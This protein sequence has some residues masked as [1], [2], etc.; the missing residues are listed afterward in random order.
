MSDNKEHFVTLRYHSIIIWVWLQ[1]YFTQNCENVPREQ[2]KHRESLSL[3]PGMRAEWQESVRPSS[4]PSV[5]ILPSTQLALEVWWGPWTTRVGIVYIHIW[6][7]LWCVGY[8]VMQ[9][10]LGN[11]RICSQWLLDCA[12]TGFPLWLSQGTSDLVNLRFFL[13]NKTKPLFHY[14]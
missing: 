6:R 5:P 8:C 12:D 11:T 7:C 9:V 4:L 14:Y 3:P 1:F 2:C 13:K 10:R